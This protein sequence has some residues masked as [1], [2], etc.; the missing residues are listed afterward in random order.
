LPRPIGLIR[1]RLAIFEADQEGHSDMKFFLH[2]D[3]QKGFIHDLEGIDFPSVEKAIVE[4]FLGIRD[5]AADC[6]RSGEELTLQ[7]IAIADESGFV[8]ATITSHDALQGI[9]P[10]FS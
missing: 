7:A 2:V 1:V 10:A 5:I 9:L 4:T 8:F 6:L 3:E